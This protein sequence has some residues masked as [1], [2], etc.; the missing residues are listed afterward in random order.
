MKMSVATKPTYF[1]R[2]ATGL[3]R[4]YGS[5]TAFMLAMNNMIGAGIFAL[6]VRAPVTW[7]GA[8]YTVALIIGLVINL[9][10]ALTYTWLAT[11]MPRSGADYV[12]VSRLLNPALS[13]VVTFGLFMGR[14]FSVGFLL[15]TDVTL[16][17]LAFRITGKATNND[18]LIRFGT[19][20]ATD[21]IAWI[22]GG[23][24]LLLT[25]WAV[26]VIGGRLFTI[27]TFIIWLIPLLGA[28]VIIAY[29]VGNPFEP[30]RFK[31]LW[32]STWG[33]GAY[34]E[35]VTL[36]TKNGWTASKYLTFDWNSTIIALA[37]AA[38]FAYAGFD[39]PAG[40]AGEVKRPERSFYYGIALATLVT[41]I[42]YITLAWSTFYAAGDF[43]SQFGVAQTRAG[44]EFK[45]NLNTPAVIPL[46]S[47]AFSGGNP[48]VA[49]LMAMAGAFALYHVQPAA[50]MKDT[51]RMFAMA[52]DNFLPRALADVSERFHTP[53]KAITTFAILGAVGIVLTGAVTFVKELDAIRFVLSAIS[54]TFFYLLM[55]A[56]AGLA[57]A[58]LPYA[59]PE[60]FESIK[61]VGSRTV[62]LVGVL[63]FGIS[64]YFLLALGYQLWS[65]DARNILVNVG[66]LT[67]GGLLFIYYA[68]KNIQ[69]GIDLRGLFREIPP[70]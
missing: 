4:E 24:V 70:E 57:I 33:A 39:A 52:F 14:L 12:A 10:I 2:E 25:I 47:V 51:R 30:G 32:D 65:S 18:F 55:A 44:K 17:G 49:L 48:A 58:V 60:I 64:M 62:T 46:F 61:G 67:L 59:R 36:A 6:T 41:G 50:L 37:A 35:I 23:L 34:D 40:I 5:F 66:V 53:V 9:L 68:T 38:M 1:V 54:A 27:Y 31:A 45:I 43:V 8:D 21:A 13:Y 29:Q 56:M 15:V 3:V 42:V 26:L 20:L 69:R 11:S 16:W 22:I 63:T 19:Y 28:L 7:P